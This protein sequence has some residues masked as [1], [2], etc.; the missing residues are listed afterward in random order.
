MIS[1]QL[2]DARVSSR[3]KTSDHEIGTIIG[4]FHFNTALN[5]PLVGKV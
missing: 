4:F 1:M 5:G 3:T 2:L